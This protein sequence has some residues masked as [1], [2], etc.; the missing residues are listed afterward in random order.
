MGQYLLMQ[1][2]NDL[3]SSIGTR[4][5]LYFFN[6][7]YVYMY[8]SLYISNFGYII[9]FILAHIYIQGFRK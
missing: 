9:R 2:E 6:S 8:R 3:L 4:L 7:I 1:L 5:F